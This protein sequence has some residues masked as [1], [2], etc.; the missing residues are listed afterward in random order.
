MPFVVLTTA[1]AG[2]VHADWYAGRRDFNLRQG[3]S[4][5]T[6][7]SIDRYGNK[8]P[9]YFRLVGAN[10]ITAVVSPAPITGNTGAVT[11]TVATNAPLGMQNPLLRATIG[12]SVSDQPFAINVQAAPVAVLSFSP[13]SLSFNAQAGGSTATQSA[14]LRNSGTAAVTVSS[15]SLS[16]TNSSRFSL[17]ATACNG[18]SLAAGASCSV[19]VSFSPSTAGSFSGRVNVSSS[20]ATNPSLTLSSTVTPIV[21]TMPAVSVT[22]ASLSFSAL[23]RNSAVAQS[24]TVRNSGTAPLAI[25]ALS[26]AGS[27]ASLY[28]L[29]ASGCAGRSVAVGA[30]CSVSVGFNG[31][32]T[33]GT[34]SA[35]LNIVSNAATN[36]GVSLNSVVTAPTVAA[37]TAPTTAHAATTAPTAT[38]LLAFPEALGFGAFATGGRGGD[39]CIVA[40]LNTSGAGSLQDCIDSAT[41]P[42]TIVFRVSGLIN[43]YIVFRGKSHITLAGQ[44]SPQ[45]IIVRG[46]NTDEA[47]AGWCDQ[48]EACLAASL[49]S[50]D[51]IVRNIRTRP[52]GE[53]GLALDDGLRIRSASNS[54]FDHI[55]TEEASDE[56]IEISF[57]HDITVQNTLLAE[58]LGGHLY[59]GMLINYSAPRIGMPLDRLSLINNNWNRLLGRFPEISRESPY[60]H[61]DIMEIEIIN[62]L[63]WDQH[64]AADVSSVNPFTGQYLAYHLNWIGNYSV[65]RTTGFTR[66]GEPI[67]GA[68]PFGMIDMH[69]WDRLVPTTVAYFSDNHMQSYPTLMDW[70]LNYCCNDFFTSYASSA[71]DLLPSYGSTV[72]NV[73]TGSHVDHTALS[74]D[75]VKRHVFENVGAFPRDAEDH[76]LMGAV[77]SGVIDPT[78]VY[79]N[80]YGDAFSITN[81]VTDFPAD[82]DN[83]GMPD[84][85]EIS[86]GLNPNVDD[87][88]GTNLSGEGYTNIEVYLNELANQI[89]HVDSSHCS[90]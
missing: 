63:L 81:N 87:H 88:N 13:A 33:V 6:S 77:C 21:I 44:T 36:P 58:T 56:S 80:P 68:Y 34:F 51:L 5:T 22:P 54:I 35:Q 79:E 43:N 45:G 57:S 71:R 76:R 31:S 53:N 37:T 25:S 84:A 40:N 86:H 2:D 10:G 41:G 18:R 72:P 69:M 1:W 59:N 50:S 66:P 90:F 8:N 89:V 30:N 24:V 23:I 29:N 62:N 27:S 4:F 39:V 7:I 67:Y 70:A 11:F 75:Q 55:S 14:S 19:S 83:D 65:T 47:G 38:G 42:R 61:E 48:N 74:A 46:I 32:P 26:L 64:A 60:A 15:L 28:N 73:F 17:N 78:N 52:N 9:A 12:N 3:Q 85:W 82:S 49:R 16:G 20:L